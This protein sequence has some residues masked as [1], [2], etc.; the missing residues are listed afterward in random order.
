MLKWDKAFLVFKS[1]F[2]EK[3]DKDDLAKLTKEQLVDQVVRVHAASMEALCKLLQVEEQEAISMAL[4]S[5][6]DDILA[7]GD[8]G[9]GSNEGGEE[10]E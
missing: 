8:L 1:V 5:Q 7:V 2:E 6:A 4:S 3:P 9:F 10:G